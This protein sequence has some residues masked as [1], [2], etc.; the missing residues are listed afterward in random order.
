MLIFTSITAQASITNFDSNARS[1]RTRN[2]ESPNQTLTQNQVAAIRIDFVA[3][4]HAAIITFMAS[5]P[6]QPSREK[7]FIYPNNDGTTQAFWSVEFDRK[8]KISV[9]K[10]YTRQDITQLSQH[11][12]P[13][14]DLS[15]LDLHEKS[16]F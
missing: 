7:R 1:K 10:T 2:Q 8:N 11:Y 3:K 13:I 15:G 4:F 12:I 9:T 16:N 6:N 5:Q 14:P